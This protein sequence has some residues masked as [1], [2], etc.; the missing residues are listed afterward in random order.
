MCVCPRDTVMPASLLPDMNCSN[1]GALDDQ[2]S[3]QLG[4]LASELS[5]LGLSSDDS[6]SNSKA[7]FDFDALDNIENEPKLKRSQNTT[8]CVPVPSSEHVAEIVGRQ[9]GYFE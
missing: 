9:G 4:I 8:E 5:K 3:L 2:R 6:L 1:G 7:P